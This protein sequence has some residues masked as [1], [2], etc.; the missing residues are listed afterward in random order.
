MVAIIKIIAFNLYLSFF[1][2]KNQNLRI[3]NPLNIDKKGF[4]EVNFL[5][6]TLKFNPCTELI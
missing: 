2:T 5:I 4:K 6:L 1:L 3:R